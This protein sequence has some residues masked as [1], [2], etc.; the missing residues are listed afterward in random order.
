L[1]HRTPRDGIDTTLLHQADCY[2]CR[3]SERWQASTSEPEALQDM[4]TKVIGENWAIY[5]P[6]YLQSLDAPLFEDDDG[7][8]VALL[9]TIAAP[10]PLKPTLTNEQ[11]LILAIIESVRADPGPDW[12]L[13]PVRLALSTTPALETACLRFDNGTIRQRWFV[14]LDIEHDPAFKKA[15]A[16]LAHGLEGFIAKAKKKRAVRET[17]RHRL[18]GLHFPEIAKLQNIGEDAARKRFDRFV[19]EIQ[20]EYHD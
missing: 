16:D 8:Q 4:A 9:E 12:E 2:E 15:R 11:L 17:I 14:P 10:E 18:G 19:A 7:N 3:W 20:E 13:R 5:E 1:D 6:E